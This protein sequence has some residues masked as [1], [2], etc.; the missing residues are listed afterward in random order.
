MAMNAPLQGTAA[1]I[2]KL[3]MI[4][5]DHALSGASL[6]ART[7]LTIQIHDELLYEIETDVLVTASQMIK[8]AMESIITEP[9]PFTVS[10]KTGPNWAD[11][12]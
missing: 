6:S 1:D 7:H 8:E 3:A 10:T 4:K 9:I 5:A 2:I 11:L 12:K